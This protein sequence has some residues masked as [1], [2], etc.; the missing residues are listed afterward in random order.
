MPHIQIQVI[1]RHRRRIDPHTGRRCRDAAAVPNYAKLEI[2]HKKKLLDLFQD[3]PNSF[4][5]QR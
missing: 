5:S 4:V 2:S 1:V 3:N